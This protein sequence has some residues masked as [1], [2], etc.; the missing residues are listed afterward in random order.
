MGW[1]K[2]MEDN[3]RHCEGREPFFSDVR[4]DYFPVLISDEVVTETR[5]LIFQ[6]KQDALGQKNRYQDRFIECR[7]CG[8][9]FIFSGKKQ[10]EYEKKR[11]SAPK[12][13]KKCR[14]MDQRSKQKKVM[15]KA[16]PVISYGMPVTWATN[17]G[18]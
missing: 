16:Y 5:L 6:S 7:S 13:C 3:L 14:N 11:W 1:A 12:R 4:C 15:P 8:R 9:E 10:E 2:Y 18:V 17:M